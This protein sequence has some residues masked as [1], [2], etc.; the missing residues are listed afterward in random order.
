MN[1]AVIACREAFDAHWGQKLTDVMRPL[2][3]IAHSLKEDE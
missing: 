3:A 2:H 1:D